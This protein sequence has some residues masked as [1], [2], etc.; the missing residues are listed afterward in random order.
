MNIIN[1]YIYYL[2]L[3]LCKGMHRF[4]WLCL[5]LGGE[6][7]GDHFQDAEILILGSSS[8]VRGDDSTAHTICNTSALGNEHPN[9][10]KCQGKET[11]RGKQALQTPS[12]IFSARVHALT[13]RDLFSGWGFIPSSSRMRLP[14][15]EISAE[16]LL[17]FSL[18]VCTI[19]FS[20]SSSH[21][22]R[23]RSC[24][25]WNW[26]NCLNTDMIF[27]LSALACCCKEQIG[28][29]EN[30]RHPRPRKPG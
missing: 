8:Q 7:I 27:H 16:I 5:G 20:V 17:S 10:S 24:S 21:I 19:S 22:R 2:L 3:S 23:S 13:C 29:D 25:S 12:P 6:E 15:W 30:R 1:I 11:G 4:P 9:Y 28:R 18:W 14:R 26:C